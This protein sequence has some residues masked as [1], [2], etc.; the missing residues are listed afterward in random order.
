MR[1]RRRVTYRPNKGQA[2]FA[3]IVGL[4]F[5]GIGLFMVIPALGPFGILW[6]LI[7]VGSTV[8]SFYQAFGKKYVG[9]EIRIEDE[10]APPASPPSAPS[11]SERLEQLESLRADGLITQEEFQAKREEILKEL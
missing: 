5:V 3:G 11:V 2:V 8:M 4:I 6:T 7:A 1:R 10:D 9:P